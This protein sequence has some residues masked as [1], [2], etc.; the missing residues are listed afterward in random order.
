MST[1]TTQCKNTTM[2]WIRP[3]TPLPMVIIIIIIILIILIIII[4]ILILII[5]IILIIMVPALQDTPAISPV[6]DWC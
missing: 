4:I 2:D 1:A 3:E 6:P 5:I